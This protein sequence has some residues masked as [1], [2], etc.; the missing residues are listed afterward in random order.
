MISRRGDLSRGGY[1]EG[2]RSMIWLALVSTSFA[3]GQ[4]ALLQ[5]PRICSSR[6]VIV[7]DGGSNQID[8]SGDG[9]VLKTVE[10]AGSGD[11][12]ERGSYCEVH[13]VGRALS[14]IFD[15]SRKRNK[16]FKF[17]LGFRE[18][19]AGWDIGVASMQVGELATLTCSPQYAYGSEGSPPEIPPGATLT[20]EVELLSVTPPKEEVAA[21]DPN[22]IDYDDLMLLMD[23]ED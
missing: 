2:I 14:R 12:P 4:R 22:D 20:F 17:E 7:A 19:I 16:T 13:Y 1:K 23:M 21:K 8:I 18:V 6:A 15:S 11:V 10:R 5:Q 3:L 9:G